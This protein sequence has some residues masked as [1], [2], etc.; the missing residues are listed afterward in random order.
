MKQKALYEKQNIIC[1]LVDISL[2]DHLNEK[3]FIV[4]N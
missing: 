3:I 4:L 1:G 2:F